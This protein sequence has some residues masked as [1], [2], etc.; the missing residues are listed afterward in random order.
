MVCLTYTRV[1]Q[2]SAGF[3]NY[4]F[5]LL[6]AAEFVLSLR[7]P[8]SVQMATFSKYVFYSTRYF[9]LSFVP[10]PISGFLF[11][12]SIFFLV[13][14]IPRVAFFACALVP[15]TLALDFLP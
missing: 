11:F 14:V 3:L 1:K 15:G 10:Y 7:V 5:T 8:S 13:P 6:H 2:I 4:L 9:C 12:C